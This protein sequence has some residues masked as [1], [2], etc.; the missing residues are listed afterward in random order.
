MNCIGRFCFLF[1]ERIA[2]WSQNICFGHYFILLTLILFFVFSISFSLF[3][4]KMPVMSKWKK[5]MIILFFCF[6]GVICDIFVS[7]ETH[8]DHHQLCYF[9]ERH[10]YNFSST[11]YLLKHNLKTNIRRCKF[12]FI[13]AT[14][15]VVL[16]FLSFDSFRYSVLCWYLL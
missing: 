6:L 2:M 14:Y 4:M 13:T 12:H 7:I 16:V 9:N 11:L 10:F 3:G 15:D 1:L 5:W 8:S